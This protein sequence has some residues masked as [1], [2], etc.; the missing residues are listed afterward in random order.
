[1]KRARRA[2]VT[3]IHPKFGDVC[4]P[5]DSNGRRHC[6]GRNRFGTPIWWRQLARS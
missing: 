2:R 6:R 1:M 3:Q 4:V 5:A